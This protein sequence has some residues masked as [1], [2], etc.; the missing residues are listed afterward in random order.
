MKKLMVSTIILLPILLLAILLVSGA[1]MSMVTHIYVESV[2]FIKNE[3]LILTMSDENAPPTYDVTDEI[4]I[5][6]LR[7]KN[8]DLKFGTDDESI[9]T[10]DENGVV[11][12]SYYGETYIYVVSK[13]NKAA[14]AKRKVIVT[15][16]KVHAISLN[17][18]AIGKTDLYEGEKLELSVSFIPKDAENKSL[19]WTSDND[20]ILHVSANG[21]ITAR[22]AGKATITATSNDDP[23]KSDSITFVCH[24]QLRDLS[25]ETKA[26]VSPLKEFKLPTVT[27]VPADADAQI[28]YTSS[29]ESIATVDEEGNVKF[30][31]EGQVTITVTGEDFGGH[32]VVKYKSYTS[33][34]GYYM[35]PLFSPKEYT[36]NYEDYKDGTTPL[37]IAFA[38]NLAGTSREFKQATFE[39]PGVLRVDATD[40]SD[41]KFYFVGEMPAGRTSIRVD[42]EAY[43]YKTGEG[44][45]GTTELFS[46][47]FILKAHCPQTTRTRSATPSQRGTKLRRPSRRRASSRSR[48]PARSPSPSPSSMRKNM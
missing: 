46:D 9:V 28:T 34:D 23:T 27:C 26:V 30:S 45:K 37:P 20:D 3:A 4:T 6:P 19:K 22:G 40:Q 42:V 13:E 36:V 29:D 18:D 25:F 41:I 2:E 48:R 38:P 21:T 16:T 8:R 44:K 14:I 47:Y 11:K 31:R 39:I 12:A 43:V 10:V 33:T 24:K 7:A 5:L 15:D 17:R 32:K 1:I 35:P